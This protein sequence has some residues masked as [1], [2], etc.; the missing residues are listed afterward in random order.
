MLAS[1]CTVLLEATLAN[2]YLENEPTGIHEQGEE[3]NKQGRG[4]TLGL[5]QW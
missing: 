5:E 4:W 3:S 2:D 1:R